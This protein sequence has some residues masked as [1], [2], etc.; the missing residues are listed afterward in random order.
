MKTKAD[1]ATL[2]LTA[3]QRR[4]VEEYVK[5]HNGSQAVIRAGFSANGAAVYA[6]RLLSK[7]NIKDAVTKLDTAHSAACG[8]T[9]EWVLKALKANYDRATAATP[10]LDKEGNPAGAYRWDGPSA[11]RAAELIGKHLAMFTEN[12]ALRTPDGPM[13]IAVTHRVVDPHADRD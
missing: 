8:L 4:F 9:V 10:V 1:P 5:D 12:V 2:P 6:T 13:A 7:S 3:R 11:N